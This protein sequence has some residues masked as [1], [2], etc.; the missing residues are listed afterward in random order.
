LFTSKEL[1]YLKQL[2]E[3]NRKL[4]LEWSSDPTKDRHTSLF[5]PLQRPMTV[6]ERKNRSFIKRKMTQDAKELAY[7]FQCNMLPEKL[8]V[9]L[10][11][12]DLET[13]VWL[14]KGLCWLNSLKKN[15][16][17]KEVIGTK[18]VKY[19]V[20]SNFGSAGNLI[21]KETKKLREEFRAKNPETYDEL[22]R[23]MDAERAT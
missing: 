6:D 20:V 9:Q 18:Y 19:Q 5:D 12:L 23:T 10:G 13:F 11:V 1:N 16:D 3:R 17:L 2:E 7:A 14:F 21:S 8:L 22:E 15:E 4:I